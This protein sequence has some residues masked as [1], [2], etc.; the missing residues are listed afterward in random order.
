MI[1]RFFDKL[2]MT[3]RV[4]RMTGRALRMTG[5]KGSVPSTGSG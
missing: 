2:R 3:G 1:G 5:A 4:L